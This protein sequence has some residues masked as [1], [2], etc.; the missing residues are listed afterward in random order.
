MSDDPQFDFWYAVNNTSILLAPTSELE[1]FGVTMLN[2][3]LV[4]E[5]LD[6]ANKI[7]IREGKVKAYRPEIITPNTSLEHLLDGFGD[8]GRHYAEWLRENEKELMILRYGFGIAKQHVSEEVVTGTLVQ[9]S[10]Q[11]RDQVQAENDP[12]AAVVIGV[13][14]P[15]EVCIMKMMVDVVQRSAPSNVQSLR[16]RGIF[17]ESDRDHEKLKHELERDFAAAATDFSR[18]D[19]LARKLKRLNLFDD[20]EDRFFGLVRRHQKS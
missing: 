2:Y 6:D 4:T 18:L 17:S 8:E 7:R 12:L 20:Y 19:T 16:S 3:H 5:L 9:I 14:Q 10:A 1:T 15:W 13:E 11:V